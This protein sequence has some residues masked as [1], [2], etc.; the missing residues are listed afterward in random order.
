MARFDGSVVLR[1][2]LDADGVPTEVVPTRSAGIPDL[3][4]AAV[5]AVRE[6]RF[7]PQLRAGVA[8][9]SEVSVPVSFRLREAGTGGADSG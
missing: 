7:W 1:V 9:A 2:T 4:A 3:D 6:W 8:V 5:A